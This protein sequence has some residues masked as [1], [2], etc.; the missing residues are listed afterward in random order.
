MTSSSL[1]LRRVSDIPKGGSGLYNQQGKHL[2]T[3]EKSPASEE[4]NGSK[5]RFVCFTLLVITLVIF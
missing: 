5:P 1:E 2:H 3:V 4:G